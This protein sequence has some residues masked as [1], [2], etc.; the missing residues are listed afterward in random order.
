MGTFHHI[1]DKHLDRYLNEFVFRY[2]RREIIDGDRTA[3]ALA[4][5]VG[6]RLMY[7]QL[8]KD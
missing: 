1:S 7:K 5:I 4:G 8:I 3:E 2:D 6:K